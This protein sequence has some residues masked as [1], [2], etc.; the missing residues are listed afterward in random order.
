MI[1]VRR[2]LLGLFA[3]VALVAAPQVI[4]A[5]GKKCQILRQLDYP[6]DLD[7][8]RPINDANRN[9]KAV[10]GHLIQLR[11]MLY[12]SNGKPTVST[13]S[14]SWSI[15]GEI[16]KKY[17]FELPLGKIQPPPNL[18]DPSGDLDFYWFKG[19]RLNGKDMQVKLAVGTDNGRIP[20][21]P[22]KITLFRPEFRSL[23]RKTGQVRIRQGNPTNLEYGWRG[24]PGIEWTGFA[25]APNLEYA[26]VL[27]GSGELGF[28]DRV[29]CDIRIYGPG[30]HGSIWESNGWILDKYGTPGDGSTPIIGSEPPP[31]PGDPPVTGTT[32][33]LAGT[34]AP[35]IKQDSPLV[36]PLFRDHILAAID[37][38]FD[39]YFMYKPAG[40]HSIWVT[41]GR[42][43]RWKIKAGALNLHF[44]ST[45]PSDLGKWVLYG[46]PD[47][48]ADPQGSGDENP[49]EWTDYSTRLLLHPFTW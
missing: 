41:V 32:T 35:H 7:G 5:N 37:S 13:A 29:S 10:V 12:D 6:E 8:Y 19:G 47:T 18:H 40:R 2:N 20:T 49:P 16:T 28:V 25:E 33:I 15:D 14:F 42:L 45:D 48:A 44:N 38:Q 24:S 23:T 11:G 26:S 39:L 1:T 34:T 9:A 22:E 4:A 30:I 21:K 31:N 36:G 3:T 46:N 27:D 43:R 17:D